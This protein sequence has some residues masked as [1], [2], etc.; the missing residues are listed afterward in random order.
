MGKVAKIR[1]AFS[2]EQKDFYKKKTLS[3]TMKVKTWIGFLSTIAQ[4]DEMN[5]GKVKKL[6]RWSRACFIV[7]FLLIFVSLWSQVFELLMATVLLVVAGI[8]MLVWASQLK[9]QDVSNY[10]RAFFMPVLLLLREK[11]GEQAKLSAQVDFRNPRAAMKPAKSIVMG[12]NQKLY[13][14]VYIV[15][16]VKL[17]DEA[18]LEFVVQD[19]I[20]DL[21]WKKQSASGK[22]KFK[23]KTK[24]VHLCTIRITLLKAGY[25][26]D[27]TSV[28][29]VEVVETETAYLAKTKI[30]IKKMGDHVLHVRDFI[31]A[32]QLIYEQFQPISPKQ[33][34]N[35][36]PT[37]T[38]TSKDRDHD[39]EDIGMI[40]PYVWYGSYFDRYDHDSFDYVELEEGT[41]SE[42]GDS[43]FDS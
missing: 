5:D 26:W 42:G 25:T 16:K 36:K 19:E 15:S 28:S 12:R 7:G 39:E 35:Q 18:L 21:S 13:N 10:L 14:P 34:S 27:G 17:Q 31:D 22:T 9:K 37:N 33:E 20:K 23:H 30:K 29:G 2:P 4:L 41:Y 8:A 32:I 38:T 24:W 1:D 40:A 6:V 11:A 3:T 43:V